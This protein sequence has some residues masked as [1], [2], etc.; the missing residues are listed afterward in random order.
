M[1]ASPAAGSLRSPALPAR[2]P[3]AAVGH[4]RTHI[5]RRAGPSPRSWRAAAT[6][7]EV[8]RGAGA[9]APELCRALLRRCAARRTPHAARRRAGAALPGPPTPPPPL[10]APSFSPPQVPDASYDFVARNQGLVRGVPLW[11]GALGFAGLLANRFISGVRPAGAGGWA[12]GGLAA[13]S[14]DFW[15]RPPGRVAA[16]GR[17]A[18]PP[19]PRTP[20]LRLTHA[21]APHPPSKPR[22]RAPTPRTPPL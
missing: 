8:R 17:A 18:R 13:G 6:S 12:L 3:Q 14:P 4:P 9:A 19:A 10:A 2:R 16:A 22:A 1:I 7:E 20:L 15:P 21:R 5:A 11:G